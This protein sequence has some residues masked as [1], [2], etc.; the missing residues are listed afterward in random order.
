MR[1]NWKIRC[2]RIV[3]V[4]AVVFAS[5]GAMRGQ[6][7]EPQPQPKPAGRAL[8]GLNDNSTEDQNQPDN[9]GNWN[10]DNMP[11]TGLQ[12][13]TIGN[14][15]MR[16]SYWVPGLQFGST[17]QNQL[18]ASGGSNDWYSNNYLGANLSLLEQWSRSQL[19][20]NYSA[21]GLVT[22]Q[23][24]QNNGWYQQLGFGQTFQ[25]ARWQV[26]LL[27]QFSY[28]PESQFGFGGGTG[29]SSPGIGGSL[30]PS[31][32]GIGGSVVPNQSI[33]AATGPRFSNS[34]VSQIT[35]Q[36]SRRGSFTVGGSQG[37]LHFTQAGNID[38]DSYIGNAGY[39][40]QLTK[41]D[42]IGVSYLF[43]AYHYHGE[44]Q[45]IGAHS[46][47]ASYGK[48]VAKRL[49]L[50]FTGGPEITRYR[51]PVGGKSQTLSGSGG[52]SLTYAF[53]QGSIA[54][55][56]F[57]T[58]SGGSG[59]LIGANMDQVTF[60]GSRRLTRVWNVQG[61]V[62]F[63]KNR[64]LGSQTG[65]QGNDYDNIYAGGGLSRPIGREFNFSMAYMAEIQRVNP[66]ICS[67]A[68]CNTTS[69]QHTVNLSLQWHS[70]PLVLR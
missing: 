50:Q 54:A 13:P 67:G 52:A 33:Y 44:A 65:T 31:V 63:A 24:V 19:T 69:T 57:H 3:L 8:P 25:W 26:Q 39:N 58:V 56:Y 15:E 9:L 46:F 55:S 68:A 2:S 32:P 16:H 4:A 48:K 37:L 1:I 41:N 35:Y 6:E 47:F 53:R 70:R 42:S 49:A 64:P 5:S 14:P 21:G 66:T 60:S 22:T 7:P 29:L 11:L 45:A 28:L 59:V 17:I 38:T 18:G 51:V 36:T 62:G 10:P 43:T 30:G 61:N 40:Y 34:V 27:D 12:S 20:L 23:T